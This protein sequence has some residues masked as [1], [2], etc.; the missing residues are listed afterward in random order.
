MA[1]FYLILK[2]IVTIYTYVV[3]VSGLD[4]AVAN[5]NGE[6]D[7]AAMETMLSFGKIGA[8]IGMAFGVLIPLAML[9]FYI[10]AK[11]YLGRDHVVKYFEAQ[12]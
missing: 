11:L 2:I 4:A 6:A 1:I 7:P 9:G 10:W 3:T 8:L 5:Y 12:N